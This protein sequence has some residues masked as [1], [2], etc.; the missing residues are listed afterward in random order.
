ML[1]KSMMI[2]ISIL[3]AIIVLLGVLFG[4]LI[5]IENKTARDT[6]RLLDMEK[7]RMAMEAVNNKYGNYAGPEGGCDAPN[8][9]NIACDMDLNDPFMGQA[10]VP[11]FCQAEQCNYYF[12]GYS[13]DLKDYKVYFHLEK[14]VSGFE[15]G[16]YKLTKTGI[17]N[18][19]TLNK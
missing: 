16:C 11:E 18:I 15:E 6:Q 14:G 12:E 19:N 2:K 13:D 7:F 1:N 10:C 17:E 9:L 4:V 3:V 8:F 5:S